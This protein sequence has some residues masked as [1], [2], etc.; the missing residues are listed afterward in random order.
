LQDNIIVFP[1]PSPEKRGPRAPHNLP[2]SLTSL[3][4]REQEV[5]ALYALLLR[6]DV[7][8]L[9][10]VGTGGVGKTRLGLA[11]AQ[12]LLDD[13][14]DGVHF[15]SLAPI[16]DPAFVI[17]T[18]A[19]SIGL[20][21]SGSQP[22][23][24]RLKTS[25]H[26]KQRL[27][28]LD[29][30]EHVITVATLLAELLE[31][32][33]DIKLLVTSRE[34]LRLRAEQQF[35]VPPLA[36][37]DPKR[38]PDGRSLAHIPAV[39]LFIQRAQAIRSD[40]HVTTDNAATIAE[41]CLRLDGLPLAI[42]LAAARVKVLSLQALLARLD[43]RLHVLTGGARDLPERQRTLRRTIAWS[44]DLLDAP[45]QQLF[46]Q[47]SIFVGGCT[48]EAIEAVCATPHDE[49]DHVLEGV[50]SLL[51]K[52]LLQQTEQEGTEPR[53]SM[54]ETIREYGL[55]RLQESGETPVCQRT[56][57]LYYLA[58]AEEAEPHFRGAQQVLWWRRLEREQGNLRAALAWLIEQ[59]EGELALRLNGA[60]WQFWHIRGYWSEGWR[61]LEVVLS[62]PQAQGRTAGRAK[63]L[64]GAG[65][66]G[67]RLGNPVA[68]TLI[69]ESVS[70][71]REL[72]DKRG[73]ALSLGALGLSISEQNNVT[74]ACTLLEES[75]ALA[76]E[77]GDP[78][79]QATML[80]TLGR[81][82]SDLGDL[83]SARFFLEESVTLYREL[84][85]PHA[86]S[87]T[88]R[89]L[90]KVAQAEGDLIQA[91]ELAQETLALV[92]ALDNRAD[93]ARALYTLALIDVWKGD[94]EQAVSLLEEGLALAREQGDKNYTNAFQLT[95][96]GILLY[97]GD[98]PQSETRTLE[99][100]TL[101]REIGSKKNIAI[102][103]SLLGNVR[104]AQGDLTQARAVCAEAVSLARETEHHYSVGMSLIALAKVMAAEGQPEQAACLFGAAEPHIN[105][106]TELDPFERMDYERVVE[107][108]RARLDEQSFAAAW[109]E[110][111]AMTP[112]Q[113]LDAQGPV[114]LPQS[115]ST[116][117]SPAAPVKPA[118]LYPDGLTARE[119]EV[120]RLLAQG[121]TDAQIAGQ[122]VISPRTVNNHLTSIYSKIQVSSRSAATRYAMEQQLI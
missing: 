9:T 115:L 67:Y 120:L 30:F 69:Q 88:L 86:L 48:L 36:L 105:P 10:L 46:R 33:P 28:L 112:E 98:L 119:V 62:L 100:L 90:A 57:A 77:V 12:A 70:I 83:K 99:S 75:L 68:H 58:L 25:Q 14:A 65:L 73:E 23:L 92:Q 24:E 20:T 3:I 82:I 29:N 64:Y 107:G 38:I 103:L 80:R 11:V 121:L 44:Y 26:D 95:Y 18:I 85:D 71:Y 51:D 63:A 113:A 17:P 43:R 52:S 32:C 34:V 54:L 60:L 94:Y 7:R 111:R 101:C 84:N 108:V 31:A 59:E 19:H 87:H 15:V 79:I 74:A 39:H 109:A 106:R 2:L 114:T 110:G 66:F 49:A 55:E 40:F 13:F 89:N 22:V 5:K 45:E 61:W 78:W 93:I 42:E 37:P 97:Q 96:G 27:F 21:E 81:T 8:L 50:A 16:S 118:V 104:L 102:T 56:H 1:E 53:L 35:A 6:P 72:G 4:G 117:S 122:L 91:A 41:I 116:P 47:L 76:R